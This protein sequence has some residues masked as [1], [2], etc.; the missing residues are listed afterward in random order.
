M[1]LDWIKTNRNL[2]QFVTGL[3]GLLILILLHLLFGIRVGWPWALV[4]LICPAL[5]AIS[6]AEQYLA[7]ERLYEQESNEESA[8]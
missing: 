6:L 1:R 7:A 3:A 8:P 2:L 5:I 4:V